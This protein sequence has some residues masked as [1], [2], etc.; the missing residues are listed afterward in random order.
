VAEDPEEYRRRS[1]VANAGQLRTPLL[2]QANTNDEDV[3][4]AEIE[5]L[6]TAL[7]AADRHFESHIY[8]NAPGGHLFNRLD[9]RL[10]RES[11]LEIWRFLAQRLDPPRAAK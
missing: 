3:T 11:R 8:T 2:I 10:A 6:L 5:R 4:L 7:R 1:P 9:T